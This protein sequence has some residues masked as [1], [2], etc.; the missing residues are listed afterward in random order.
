ML[1]LCQHRRQDKEKNKIG[2]KPN[3]LSGHQCILYI[4]IVNV[5]NAVARAILSKHKMFDLKENLLE[6]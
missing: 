3:I 1:A 6:F 2:C 4:Y 5:R